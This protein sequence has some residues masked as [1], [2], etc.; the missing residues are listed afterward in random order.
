MQH[1]AI[2]NIILDTLMNDIVILIKIEYEQ[3]EICDK[4][5]TFYSANKERKIRTLYRP[6]CMANLL[7]KEDYLLKPYIKFKNTIKYSIL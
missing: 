1:K 5:Y 7:S 3:R 4:K 6:F 2:G